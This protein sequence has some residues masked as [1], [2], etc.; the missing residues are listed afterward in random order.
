MKK[1]NR[2]K[3]EL[4][5][6]LKELKQQEQELKKEPCT[7]ETSDETRRSSLK[8]IANMIDQNKK[9]K[10]LKDIASIKKQISDLENNYRF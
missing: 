4:E 2:I 10:F 1:L 9:K 3:Q 7:V 5:A 6:S 8:L